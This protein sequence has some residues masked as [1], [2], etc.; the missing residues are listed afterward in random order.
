MK[1]LNI[2]ALVERILEDGILT[3]AEQRELNAAILADG[4][5]SPEEKVEIERLWELIKNGEI[6]VTP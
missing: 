5:V 2:K 3:A 4:V 6:E 1:E